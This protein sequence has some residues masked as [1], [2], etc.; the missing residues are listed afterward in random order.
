MTFSWRKNI[1]IYFKECIG[2]AT[3]NILTRTHFRIIQAKK[4]KGH[5]L[6]HPCLY[7]P[8]RLVRSCPSDYDCLRL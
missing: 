7:R 4:S 1:L 6:W 3:E 2:E 8:T 5:S